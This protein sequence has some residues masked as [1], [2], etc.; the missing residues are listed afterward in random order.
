MQLTLIGVVLAFDTVVRHWYGTLQVGF[1]SSKLVIKVRVE[2]RI[3]EVINRLNKTKQELYPDLA[4]QRESYDRGIRLARK[5]ELQV[6]TITLCCV[7]P[8][9]AVL[10]GNY[11]TALLQ[12]QCNGD[13]TVTVL[14]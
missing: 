13:H 7:L 4:A 3:N 6:S 2:K 14:V 9:L 12:L 1:H 11:C 5:S 10:L 8:T